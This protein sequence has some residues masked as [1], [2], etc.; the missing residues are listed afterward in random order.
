MQRII[1]ILILF[2]IACNPAKQILKNKEAFD[3]VGAA[4]AVQNPC[5]NDSVYVTK[6][7][8]TILTD[9]VE[10]VKYVTEPGAYGS[11]DTVR[12]VT[13]RVINNRYHT[14]DSVLYYVSDRRKEEALKMLLSQSNDRVLKLTSLANSFKTQFLIACGIGA[15]LLIAV[16][17]LVALLFK[18]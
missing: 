8:T 16:I 2:L 14:R 10:N 1:S 4:W 3:K 12:Q 18:R 13:E 9:T 15:V 11:P 6:T 5:V 7:D 17:I